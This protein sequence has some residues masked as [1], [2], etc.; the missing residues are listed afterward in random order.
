M[1]SLVLRIQFF[2]GLDEKNQQGSAA[3][4]L[5]TLLEGR[6]WK[7]AVAFAEPSELSRE[8]FGEASTVKWA[9]QAS[10]DCAIIVIRPTQADGMVEKKKHDAGASW[11]QHPQWSSI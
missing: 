7:R 11:L 1:T 8:M 6:F 3:E 4:K 10:L 2:Q 9:L 5:R